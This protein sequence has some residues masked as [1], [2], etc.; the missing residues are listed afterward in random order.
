MNLGETFGFVTQDQVEAMSMG[1]RIGV[2]NK[3][4]L[5]QVGT[6]QEIY[7]NPVNT[8]VARAVGSPAM[9]LL[10]GL[11]AGGQAVLGDGLALD[12]PDGA[13]GHSLIFGVRPEDVELAPGA[14]IAAVMT[15]V[16]NHDDEKIV[17]LT[18]GTY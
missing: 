2:L 15:D 17:S 12:H 3:S 7:S 1:D 5:V 8:F 4:V 6:P 9:K 16:E 13:E 11:M 14:P 10:P 18:A